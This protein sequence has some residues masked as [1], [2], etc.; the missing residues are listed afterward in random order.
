MVMRRVIAICI[1]LLLAG[2]VTL[3]IS[4]PG[5]NIFAAANQMTADELEKALGPV[6]KPSKHYRIGA[7]EKTLINEHWQEMKKG[8]EDAAKKYGITVEVGAVDTEQDLMKQLNLAETFI[9]KGYDALA[10]SPLTASNLVPALEKARKKGIPILNVD[11]S[12]IT[13]VPVTAFVGAD[14]RLMGVYAADYFGKHIKSGKV[15]LIE[16]MAGSP[17]SQQRVAGFTE[18][19]KKYPGLK[20]VAS[21]PGNWD[22]VQAM[23]AATNIIR[24][25]PDLKA[26]YACN[27]TMALGVV[28]AVINAGKAG[29]IMVIGTDGVP[30]AIKSIREGKMTGTIAAFP[31][32]MGRI[33]TEVAIRVLEGQKVPPVIVSPMVLVTKDNVD[34]YFKK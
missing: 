19:I 3:S 2:A 27:D 1:A 12:R 26:I 31:Y 9:A 7:I 16:G 32:E 18:T 13:E 34:K 33:A 25:H 23:N 4:R 22:R 28:E 10:V 6:P 20:L 15:A 17:A 5:G 14:H 29:K 24:V 11:D 8:Y 30:D 21:Q